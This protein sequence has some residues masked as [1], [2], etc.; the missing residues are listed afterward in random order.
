VDP[1]SVVET[2]RWLVDVDTTTGSEGALA[3]P[4]AGW[5]REIGWTVVEQPVGG[6]RRNVLATIEPPRVVFSTHYDC[7]PP[8]F[9]SRLEGE[10]LYGRGACDAKGI[11]VA[12]VAAAERLRRD[13]E[14]RI[15][16]LF[17]VGEER[18]SDGAMAANTLA[19]DCAYLVNGEPTDNRLATATRGALRVR[20]HAEG[21]AAHSSIPEHGESAIEKLVDALVR[22]RAMSW[23]DDQMLGRTHYTVGLIAGGIAPNVVP[24]AAHAEVVFR[25]VGAHDAVRR[26]IAEACSDLRVEDVLEFPPVRMA[27]VPGFETAAFPFGTDV[28]F[29]TRWG[30]PLLYGPGSILTAH[31]DEEHVRIADLRRAVDDYERLARTLLTLST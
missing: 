3:G 28:P 5:L 16:L 10:I 12:Q 6:D 22:L 25:T 27:T 7:V 30:R 20:L 1:L 9:P 15:G 29:L 21:R 11:L 31:T 26:L 2:T 8:F 17:V 14:G 24:P 18:G 19:N 23:P 13:G 4:L